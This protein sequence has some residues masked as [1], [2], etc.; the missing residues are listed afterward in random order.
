MRGVAGVSGA[1][2]DL[3]PVDLCPVNRGTNRPGGLTQRVGLAAGDDHTGAPAGELGG[4]GQPDA[5]TR[6]RDEGGSAD[7]IR[8]RERGS[9]GVSCAI[10]HLATVS[11]DVGAAWASGVEKP[12][13]DAQ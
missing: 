6:A 2:V 12:E 13:V 1:D 5:A 4:D 7:E 9:G 11:T 8:G 10:S 3:C